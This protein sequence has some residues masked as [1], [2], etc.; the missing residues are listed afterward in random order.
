ML[1]YGKTSICNVI[2]LPYYVKYIKLLRPY[3]SKI[4][5]GK[6]VLNDSLSSKK[7]LYS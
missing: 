5:N 7:N 2:A 3:I 4:Y 1:K 6:R